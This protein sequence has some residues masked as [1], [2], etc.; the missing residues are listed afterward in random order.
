MEKKIQ[1]PYYKLVLREYA[2]PSFCTFSKPFHGKLSD[3]KGLMEALADDN[4]RGYHDE[5]L[6]A[7]RAWE[8]GDLD[9]THNVAYQE[10]QLLTP[11]EVIDHEDFSFEN[12]IWQHANIWDSIYELK[13]DTID[14]SQIVMKRD[15]LFIRGIRPVFKKLMVRCPEVPIPQLRDWDLVG[16]KFFGNPHMMVARGEYTYPRLFMEQATY[17]SLEEAIR[18]LH[19]ETKIDFSVVCDE[20][21][22]D[23]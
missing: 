6:S 8:L 4:E 2:C 23:G 10:Y 9:V 18:D 1:S 17:E 12:V 3:I 11:E 13:A 15:N 7:F 5:L 20:I 19:D 16:D 22:G 14:V 21:F